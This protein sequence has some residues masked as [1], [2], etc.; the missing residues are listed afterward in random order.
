MR[1]VGE[2]DIF[3]PVRWLS[4]HSDGHERERE[5][6]AS[7]RHVRPSSEAR[8]EVWNGIESAAHERGSAVR[9]STVPPMSGLRFVA[10]H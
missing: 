1:M 9:P 4:P 6:L 10:P 7:L 2:G 3:D 5:F 8:H